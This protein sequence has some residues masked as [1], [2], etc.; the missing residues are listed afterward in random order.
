MLTGEEIE[1][2][3]E[4]TQ[5]DNFAP[6]IAATPNE[7]QKLITSATLF[8]LVCLQQ[9]GRECSFRHFVQGAIYPQLEGWQCK[10]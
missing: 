5:K 6:S 1:F 4:K 10:L 3:R 9:D 2:G 8:N 7:P